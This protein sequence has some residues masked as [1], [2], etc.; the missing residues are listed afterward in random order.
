MFAL[1]KI[2]KISKINTNLY[3]RLG[4]LKQ[5]MI[6]KSYYSNK[7]PKQNNKITFDK[8]VSFSLY[9]GKFCG[10]L[11]F[12]YGFIDTILHSRSNFFCAVVDSIIVGI[13]YGVNGFL[14][15][16]S[17]IV[18]GPVYILYVLGRY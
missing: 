7:I 15:G 6:T 4:N 10:I 14:T 8:L 3:T 5:N 13:F 1:R 16:C 11:G 18:I 12:T 2:N 17:I 9:C